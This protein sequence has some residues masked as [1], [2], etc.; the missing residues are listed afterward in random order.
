MKKEFDHNDMARVSQKILLIIAENKVPFF[1]ALEIC[2]AVTFYC[3]KMAK[4]PPKE[5]VK[6]FDDQR[7]RYVG[8]LEFTEEHK[9]K[10]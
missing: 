7:T 10:I 9:K 2:S 4:V 1:A 8:Y 5:S 6:F 3:L